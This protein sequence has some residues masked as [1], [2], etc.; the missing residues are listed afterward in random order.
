MVNSPYGTWPSP[1]S[2]AA[3]AAQSVR[4]SSVV[5][6]GED[7]YWLEGRPSEGGRSVLV[8]RRAD[9]VLEDVTPMPF[10]VRTRVHEY[11]GG[12]YLVDRGT[13][14]FS[15]F[16]DQRIYQVRL[17]PDP[18]SIPT[19]VTPAGAWF[20]ADFCRDCGR[21]RLIAVREDHSDASREAIT[22]LVAIS[23]DGDVVVIASGRDFYATPR[24]SPDGTH[25]SWLCWDHPQMPW[26]GTELWVADIAPDG[27]LAG[28]TRVAGGVQE[29]IFQ[30]GW[31]SDSSL[32]FADDRSGWWQ[33][34]RCAMPG[35]K[36]PGLQEIRAGF[37]GHVT[38]LLRES[39][40]E[41]EFGR[42]LWVFGSAV[43]AEAAP[44]TIV[45]TWALKGV[46]HLGVIDVDAGTL[47]DLEPGF[48]PQDWLAASPSHAYL[49]AGSP[50]RAPALVR[51]SLHDPAVDVITESAPATMDAADVSEAQA[52]E[53]PGAG[54][55]IAHAFY[56]PPRNKDV[57]CRTGLPP[58]VAIS[59]GGPTA[60]ATRTFD[61]RIQYW[62]TRGFAVVD[63]NYGGSTGYGRQYRE[64]LRGEWG[65]VDVDDMIHAVTHLVNAGKA[66]PDRL[67]IRGG[68]A[69]GYTT[70]AA[71]TFHPGV[72]KAGASY[73]GV[74][75]LE[76]LARDTHK[77]EAR[78]LDSLVGPYPAMADEYRKRSPIHATDKLA[79]A[80][81]FFQGLDDRV[82]PPNQSEGMAETVRRKGLPVAYVAFEGE[83]H[84]FRKADNIVRSLEAELYFYAT[85]FGFRPADVLDPVNIDNL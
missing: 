55:A 10:N 24:V 31:L 68:S 57:E 49:I 74:S 43:W 4:L 38:P 3:V 72:F 41:S 64:R 22:T 26:D 83:Q 32:V 7:V 34:Y 67:I 29:S 25:L 15:N 45:A 18:T 14:W 6:D 71:L 23:D 42:P 62:T 69:G 77:F 44:G 1:I 56:Y 40:P 2:A 80:L 19:P 65:H 51:V 16:A 58:L 9:G 75:D 27:T 81:I 61:V 52:I 73:Y 53:C 59:H 63:V 60:A 12:A 50:R 13:A 28:A 20:Y 21:R 70:L 8:R 48:D 30:P 82:V 35:L 79:C 36:S 47:R 85:V 39:P 17:K 54:G 33:L 11:G 46:W 76:L 5:L 66:D 78:Y 37:G 84:G